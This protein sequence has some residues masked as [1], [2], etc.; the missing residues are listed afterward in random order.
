MKAVVDCNS[1]YASCERVFEPALEHK[2]VVVLSNNDGCIVSRTEEAK[3]L[4]IPMAVPYF[5]AREIIEKHGVRVFSSNYALYGDMSNR[6]MQILQD[7]VPTMEVYSI[8]EAFLDL[9][10]IPE[11]ELASWGRKM[12]A[13]IR[14]W[15]GI[16]VSIG[17]APTKTLSKVATHLAK[18]KGAHAEGVVALLTNGEQQE[19]LQQTPAGE[20]W[21]IG[22][23]SAAKL[24][25][26][27]IYTAWDLCSKVSDSWV[28]RHLGGVVGLR[29]VKELK[30]VPCLDIAPPEEVFRQGILC[31]R[32][33][34]KPVTTLA[35]LKEA[36]ATYMV[37]AAEK[38]REQKSL[39]GSVSVFAYYG[40]YGQ[41][42][43]YYAKKAAQASLVQ[44]TAL[45]FPLLKEAMK[46]TEDLFVPGLRY[47]KA[48]VFLSHIIA[49]NHVQGCLFDSPPEEKQTRKLMQMMDGINRD[50]GM[51]KLLIAATGLKR[52]WKMRQEQRS[53]R[54][55]TS[56]KDLLVVK[57]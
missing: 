12:V 5:Q 31:S 32:S 10:N 56:W 29:L 7:S 14:Q 53:R 9:E 50:M 17:I 1:F 46:L 39:A 22:F 19:A 42:G 37:R 4:G 48:G 55:T 43:R 34:G 8:D 20:V 3:A 28:S 27:G 23:R 25:K 36:I 49:D 38:L 18:R 57:A 33:F 21:G 15:T 45:S 2:P 35:D 16:P 41:A 6:V 52:N 40:N 51:D 26:A 11:K 30:G 24:E 44:P 47:K 13:Q 54:Y